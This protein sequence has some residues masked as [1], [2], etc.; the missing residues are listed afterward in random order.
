MRLD[1]DDFSQ[2]SHFQKESEE[3]K[4][5]S[6]DP[7]KIEEI[8]KIYQEK[9]LKLEQDY[10]E[11]L[12]K[13]SKESY[14]QGFEDASAKFKQELESKIAA[15]QREFEER[16]EAETQRLQEEYLSFERSYEERYNQFL[17]KFTDIVLDS[18]EEILEFLFIDKSNTKHVQEAIAKL[19]EDFHN[20]MPL[21]ISVSKK[22]YD[23]IK[24]RFR[25]V[26]VKKSDELKNNEFV[27]EFHDF[28]IENR[29]KEKIGVIKDEIKRETKKLT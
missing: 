19:L 17:H 5:E 27:I 7:K 4:E 3:I 16:L 14:D 28:K 23:A 8:E 26:Q 1:L 20:Y 9:I 24:E 2:L 10:K 12:N 6:G 15:M 21:S 25:N 29:I 22:M 18:T 11:L 13:V